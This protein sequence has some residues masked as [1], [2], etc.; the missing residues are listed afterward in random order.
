MG[1]TKKRKDSKS[2]ST[3][4]ETAHVSS[5]RSLKN[6]KSVL[7]PCSESK[8]D[9]KKQKIHKEKFED[10]DEDDEIIVSKRDFEK[11]TKSIKELSETVKNLQE[12]LLTKADLLDQ[13]SLKAKET[14]MKK[15]EEIVTCGFDCKEFKGNNFKTIFVKGF[16]QLQP[17]DDIKEALTTIFSSFGVV[18]RVFVPI[19]CKTRVPLGFA[20]IN[21]RGGEDKALELNGR[22]M[23]GRKLEV[24]MARETE[25][26]YAY[27]GFTGCG[28]CI[29]FIRPCLTGH[30]EDIISWL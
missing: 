22:R 23:G 24:K 29:T 27:P 14:P 9:L 4:E 15:E 26:F 7:A 18:T 19:E 28:R 20:F 3:V 6:G 8:T 13:V 17:R 30:R 5:S 12:I 2:S 1:K 11:M 25:E 16:Q 10:N 21:L